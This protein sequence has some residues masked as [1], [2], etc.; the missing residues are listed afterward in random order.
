MRKLQIDDSGVMRIAIQQEI[1]RSEE[2]R[3]DH[4][5]HALLLLAAGH[6]CREVAE[7]FGEDDT[8]VQRWVHR[9]QQGG[10]QAL[11]ESERP[12]RPRS[13]GPAAVA[14]PAG[15]SREEP[16]RFRPD[17]RALGRY[18][19][20]RAPAAP[21]RR[22][23]GGSPVPADL[24]PDGTRR[25]QRPHPHRSSFQRSGEDR[26]DVTLTAADTPTRIRNGS[27]P[28]PNHARAGSCP[29]RS[30]QCCA[31]LHCAAARGGRGGG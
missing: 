19:S 2:A 22:T 20:R 10:L 17:G 13:L 21:L 8:T 26:S 18:Q 9:V 6:S 3:Y 12:G 14:Q 4:R 24:P 16:A 27:I 29:P 5:L 7:L 23:A 28:C 1:G 25:P 11:R 30:L 15:G 31:S